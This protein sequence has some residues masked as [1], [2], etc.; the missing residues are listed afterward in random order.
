M[1]SAVVLSKV[2]LM[3]GKILRFENGCFKLW[4]VICSK[5]VEGKILRF[6]NGCFQL[7]SIIPSKFNG[8]GKT[9][10]WKLMILVEV[11]NMWLL[12]WE[13]EKTEVWKR[14]LS[15]GFRYLSA[16]NLMRGKILRF[17]NGC[18]QLGSVIYLQSI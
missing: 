9:E 5:F 6:E 15:A 2:N 3:R 12:L 14:M 11:P 8:K 7:G 17:E 13:K 1:L 4:S 16:V 10:V 18:F